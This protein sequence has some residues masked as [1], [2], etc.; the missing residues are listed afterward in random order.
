MPVMVLPLTHGQLHADIHIPFMV[1]LSAFHSSISSA[2][3]CSLPGWQ[4][5]LSYIDLSPLP[6]TGDLGPES[7][8][9]GKD[10]IPASL[11][12]WTIP[13]DCNWPSVYTVQFCDHFQSAV[14]S[15]KQT[16]P[17]SQLPKGSTD[18]LAPAFSWVF[19]LESHLPM[20]PSAPG[21]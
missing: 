9:R 13:G 4:K 19:T 12:S 20:C 8:L 21:K 10:P 18:L 3:P 14:P 5:V 6:S 1:Q 2:G 16:G 17:L 11:H 7:A 15:I